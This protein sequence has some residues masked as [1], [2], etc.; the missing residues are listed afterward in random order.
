[1]QFSEANFTG[2]GKS[3]HTK[4]KVYV[5]RFIQNPSHFVQKTPNYLVEEGPAQLSIYLPKIMI[6]L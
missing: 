4:L 5:F 2:K 3:K 6:S 1:M